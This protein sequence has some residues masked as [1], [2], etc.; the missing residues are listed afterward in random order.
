MVRL[1][2][3]FKTD[4]GRCHHGRYHYSDGVFSAYHCRDDPDDYVGHE[5]CGSAQARGAEAFVRML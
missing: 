5:R 1:E 4:E 3:A 2:Q